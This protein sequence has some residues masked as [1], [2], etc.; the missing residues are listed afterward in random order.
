MPLEDT[1][2]FRCRNLL[3]TLSDD[4]KICGNVAAFKK[5]E[6]HGTGQTAAVNFFLI[7]PCILLY[8]M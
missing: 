8:I 2:T 1:V 5:N 3:S 6:K 7:G 4:M